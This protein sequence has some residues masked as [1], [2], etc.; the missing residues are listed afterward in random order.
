[1]E[2]TILTRDAFTRAA[3]DDPD[4]LPDLPELFKDCAGP[5][6]RKAAE[7]KGMMETDALA[8][9]F[10]VSTA[11]PD[12]D[13]DVVRVTG[14]DFA[15]WKKNPVILWAHDH[16]IPAIGRGLGIKKNGADGIV[17]TA[18]FPLRE[19]YEFGGMIGEL[20]AAKILGASS[21]G[22]I[23]SE[24]KAIYDDEERFAGWDFLKKAMIEWSVVNVPANAEALVSRAKAHKIDLVPLRDWCA[25]VLDGDGGPDPDAVPAIMPLIPKWHSALVPV[26]ISFVKN[27]DGSVILTNG[28][29]DAL[30]KAKPDHVEFVEAKAAKTK[31]GVDETGELADHTARK[32]PTMARIL[33]YTE[34]HP[35]GCGVA[36]R[37]KP[38]T[39]KTPGAAADAE[40]LCLGHTESAGWF[41]VHHEADSPHKTV[42]WTGTVA[43]MEKLAAGEFGLTLDEAGAAYDHLAKHYRDDFD[44]APPDRELV[45]C[46]PLKHLR[47]HYKMDRGTGQIVSR[48]PEEIRAERAAQ[49]IGAAVDSLG[50]LTDADFAT[51]GEHAGAVK[52]AAAVLAAVKDGK[53]LPDA[54]APEKAA[55]GVDFEA[56]L[57]D[58]IKSHLTRA[59]GAIE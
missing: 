40:P 8:F 20:I 36:K 28:S 42:N 5:M 23:P 12:R 46:Q 7:P 2:P 3:L 56:L 54:P 9:D 41:G 47:D 11:T 29:F 38:W 45:L 50:K 55:E 59:A 30:T 13:G 35:D 10:T 57:G 4:M 24:Y 22:F 39:A 51:I 32:E 14:W 1:M 53:P 33:K 27:A 6:P 37:D 17:S 48:A 52:H 25:K 43:A 18:A 15:A 58:S 26:S 19:V 49:S 16:S 31:S 21:V 44:A 34:A